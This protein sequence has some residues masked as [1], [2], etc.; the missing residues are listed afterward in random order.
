[1]C[2]VVLRDTSNM[3]KEETQRVTLYVLV[4]ANVYSYK[5]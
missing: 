5:L 1:M 4:Y 3:K 2:R